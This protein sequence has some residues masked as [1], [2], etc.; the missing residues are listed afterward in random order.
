MVK[1]VYLPLDICKSV[2]HVFARSSSRNAAFSWLSQKLSVE[3]VPMG[4]HFRG[5][6]C[7]NSGPLDISLASHIN[8]GSGRFFGFQFFLEAA[9]SDTHRKDQLR[10]T[11]IHFLVQ[12]GELLTSPLVSSHCLESAS[13]IPP[14]TCLLCLHVIAGLRELSGMF[15]MGH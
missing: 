12:E 9:V 15:Y 4:G 7:S 2:S 10:T 13:Q 8:M 5:S 3:Q 6:V 11:E 14:G 1:L